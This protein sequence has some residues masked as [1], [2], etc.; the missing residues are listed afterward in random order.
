MFPEYRTLIS[1]L[2]K[3]NTRFAVLFHE[4]S[5]LDA[6]IKKREMVAGFSDAE[7]ETLKK[8]SCR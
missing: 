1:R 6:D 8:R 7:N 2:K 3:E 5:I 4:H